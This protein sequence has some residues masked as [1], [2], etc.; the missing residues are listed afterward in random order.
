MG[1][2]KV[3]SNG[4]GQRSPGAFSRVTTDMQRSAAFLSLSAPAIRLLLWAL[5]K[6]YHAATNRT[7][8]IGNPR[9]RITNAEAAK[10]LNMGSSTFSR[11]KEDLAEKGF[12]AW[13]V[14]GGLK[15]CNGVASEFTLV[16]EWRE[17]QPQTQQ[18]RPP[19]RR[20]ATP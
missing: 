19:P 12:L 20:K 18:K 7:G 11:A 6:Q 8:E 14:R 9:F 15:G 4:R 17:W 2:P 10:E 1:G 3:G 5:W 16:N 13:A